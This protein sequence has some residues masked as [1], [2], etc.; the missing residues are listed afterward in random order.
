MHGSSGSQQENFGSIT[1]V[2]I[3]AGSLAVHTPSGM[4]RIPGAPGITA[5]W[6]ARGICCEL[7]VLFIES[8]FQGDF[9]EGISDLWTRSHRAV[10]Q[11][12][13]QSGLTHGPF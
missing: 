4:C 6:F 7:L 2:Q 8:L 10:N 11:Q 9:G 3:R 12:E 13:I 1:A 5:L